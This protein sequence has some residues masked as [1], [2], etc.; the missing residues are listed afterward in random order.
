MFKLYQCTYLCV[1]LDETM[2][3]N[4]YLNV[5]TRP[6]LV[7]LENSKVIPKTINHI[8]ALFRANHNSGIIRLNLDFHKDIDWFL[9]FSPNF[10]SITFVS[11]LK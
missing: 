7:S 4:E 11:K 1:I 2:G 3:F 9:K 5:L 8:L 10:N 6:V